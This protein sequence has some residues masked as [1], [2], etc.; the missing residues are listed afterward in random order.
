MNGLKRG[1]GQLFDVAKRTAS[2]INEFFRKFARTTAE[3]VGSPWAFVVGLLLIVGWLVSGPL[4]DFSDT[5]QLVI[6]TSTTIVTFLM[7]F[8]IQNSQNRD[9][10]ALHLKLDELIRVMDHARNHLVDLENR[11]DEELEELQTEFAALGQEGLEAVQEKLEEVHE[12][13][14]ALKKVAGASATT[15]DMKRWD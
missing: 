9:A 14:E 6:N 11:P 8:I 10:K 2:P 5:W 13:V 7:V 15:N 1:K 4:F 3:V 12:E